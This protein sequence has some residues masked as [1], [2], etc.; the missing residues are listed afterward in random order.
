MTEVAG[1]GLTGITNTTAIVENADPSLQRVCD[2]SG[3]RARG[4]ELRATWN[5]FMVLPQFWEKRNDQDFVRSLNIDNEGARS[6]KPRPDDR[7]LDTY[8]YDGSS[9]STTTKDIREVLPGDL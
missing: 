6:D 4:R 7:D 9:W 1:G 8:S 2:Q 3:F 5:G